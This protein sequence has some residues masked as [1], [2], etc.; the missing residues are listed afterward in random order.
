MRAVAEEMHDLVARIS[1]LEIADHYNRL[2]LRAE[3]RLR[4][5]KTAA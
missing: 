4:G 3:E 1:M 2:A 5:E